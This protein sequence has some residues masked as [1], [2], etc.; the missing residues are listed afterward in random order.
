M[1]N[2][3]CCGGGGHTHNAQLTVDTSEL[4]EARPIGCK[5]EE[6]PDKIYNQSVTIRESCFRHAITTRY[7]NISTETIIEKQF[8]KP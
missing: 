5:W 1:S 2:G 7:L 4:A 8:F 6:G 3:Q